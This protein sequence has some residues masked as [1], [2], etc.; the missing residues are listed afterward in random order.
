[1]K[2]HIVSGD[3]P[4]GSLKY[5]F[6]KN[7]IDDAIINHFDDLSVWPLHVDFKSRCIWLQ[8]KLFPWDD[9][10]DAKEIWKHIQSMQTKYLECISYLS[11]ADEIYIWHGNNIIENMMLYRVCHDGHKWRIFTIDVSNHINEFNHNIRAVWECSPED[12]GKLMSNWQ[13]ISDESKKIFS[14]YYKE[15]L[16][17]KWF[18]RV[19]KGGE[20]KTVEMDY[21]DKD[22]LDEIPSDIFTPAPR[23]VWAVLWKSEQLI[24]DSFL[25]YRLKHLIDAD[26][27]KAKWK[28]DSLRTFEIIRNI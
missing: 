5:Y 28:L 16:S 9:K 12:L 15:I 20:V 23:V 13:E 8:Q 10:K 6:K 1:M 14:H 21:Y 25:Q 22:L 4:A 19:N 2:Y 27:V 11:D 3:S 17:D 26:Q 7:N 24:W 18:L